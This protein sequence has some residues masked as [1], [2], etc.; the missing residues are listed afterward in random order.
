MSDIK[1]LKKAVILVAGFGT[2]FLPVTKAQPKEMLPLVDKPIV[3]YLVEEAA[4]AGIK[5]II[6]VTG[7]NKRAIEDHFDRAPELEQFLESR[8]KTD[9]ARIVREVSSLAHV[10]Y[11]RQKE[12][13]GTADAVLTARPF[14]GDEAFVV[15]SG[16]DIID[17]EDGQPSALAQMISVYEKYG[18]PVTCLMR[19]PPENIHRYGVIDG[20]EVEPG[21]WKIKRAVEKPAQGSAPSNLATI[22][23]FIM[24]PDFLPYLEAVP[25]VRGEYYIPPAMD[26]SIKDGHEF[27]GCEVK[28]EW[29]DCGNKLGYMKGAV[30]YA[31]RHPEIGE[32]F[33]AYLKG[34][35][36]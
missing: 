23:K 21:V 13:K 16:D 11:V 1:K 22:T 17:T 10:A 30:Q 9:L 2:R 3:Q 35:E 15:M 6:L 29:Y 19:V 20:E 12:Q 8:G 4:R 31:L 25:A 7:K 26:A 36:I 18:A 28:G 14:I 34:L 27:Y 33:R 32:E 5:E 24:T